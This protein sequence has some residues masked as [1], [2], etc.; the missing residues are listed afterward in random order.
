MSAPYYEGDGITLWLGDCREHAQWVDCDA[1][2]TDPPYG[3]GWKQGAVSKEYRNGRSTSR[4]QSPKCDGIANDSD[5]AAR[6]AALSMWGPDRPAVVFGD[7]MLAPPDGT[8]LVAVYAKP[9]A[10][11]PFGSVAGVRRTCEAIYLMGRWPGST[12]GGRPGL[13]RTTET[14]NGGSSGIV[15]KAGG[16]PHAKAMDVMRDLI[17]LTPDGASIADPFAGS[18]S[19]LVAARLMGRRA[20]GVEVEERFAEMAARRLSQG[21]LDLWGGEVG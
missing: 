6:D 17:R 18:G 2:V 1:L 20:V 10:S 4:P 9:G 21:V 3:R 7:L 12:F 8:R 19:T 13:F 14:A 16:H 11:S 15:A 5:T